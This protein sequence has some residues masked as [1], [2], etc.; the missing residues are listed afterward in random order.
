MSRP[1]SA[2]LRQGNANLATL[3]TTADIDIPD[4]PKDFTPFGRRLW[5][6][7]WTAGKNAYQPLTDCHVVERYVSL[8]QRRRDLL[9]ILE[10]E[11]WLSE[12]STGQLVIHPAAKLLDS[13]E[14]KLGPLEDRL[15]LSPEARLRLGISSV[16]H[17]SK[18]EA[19]LMNGGSN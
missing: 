2:E 14:G 17:K 6:D 11:G 1:K 4:A 7:I 10:T 19:F 5:I 12:G 18:L 13:V 9:E 8:Q 3:Q 16:E 15:G